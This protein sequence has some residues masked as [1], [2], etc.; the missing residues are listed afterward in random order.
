YI[1]NLTVILEVFKYKNIF[2]RP[3]KTFVIFLNI[4]I[5]GKLIDKFLISIIEGKLKTITKLD[6]PKTLTQLNYFIK[7]AIYLQKNIPLFGI[8]VQLLE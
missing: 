5:L 3:S 8:L 2:I 4:L 7:F 1:R 6:F